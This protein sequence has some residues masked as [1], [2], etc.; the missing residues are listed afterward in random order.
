MAMA[1]TFYVSAERIDFIA[2]EAPTCPPD[3]LMARI[4]HN[5]D[6]TVLDVRTSEERE[7]IQPL[8][9]SIHIPLQELERRIDE[10]Q[11]HRYEEIVV[12]CPN[13][14]RSQLAV[15]Q[16]RKAGFDAVTLEGGLDALGSRSAS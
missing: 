11:P 10:L 5:A 3:V 13:G 1:G 6:I 7:G 12:V 9:I 8:P 14:N 15:R 4:A 2:R 16:L